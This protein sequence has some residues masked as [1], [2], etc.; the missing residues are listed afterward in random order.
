M[1]IDLDAARAARREAKGEGP[2]V[3]FGGISYELSPELPFGVLEAMR[4]LMSDDNEK[5]PGALVDL[6]RALLGEHYDAFKA[7]QPTV[8]DLNELIGGV[9]EEYGVESPLPSSGS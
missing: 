9:M 8:D 7:T 2:R 4:E 1:A 6:T 3:I 5:A